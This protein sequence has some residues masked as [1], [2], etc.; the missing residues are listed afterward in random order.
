MVATIGAAFTASFRQLGCAGE[1]RLHEDEA[2]FE[3][4]AVKLM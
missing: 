3:N 2:D 1:V 4:F